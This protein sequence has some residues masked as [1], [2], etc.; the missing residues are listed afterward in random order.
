M[1]NITLVGTH[2]GEIGKSNSD[3]LYKI[4]ESLNPDVIFEELSTDHF[5]II[6]TKPQILGEPPEVKSIK[7]YLINHN[8]RHIPVDISLNPL[9]LTNDIENIFGAFKRYEVY[10]KLEEEQIEMTVKE[11]FTFLNSKRN[12]ELSEVKKI[13]ERNLIEFMPNKNQILR[14][15]NLFYEEQD[16]RENEWLQKIY[17]YSKENYYDKAIFTVGAG[18]R[19]SIMQKIQEYEKKEEFKLYWSF[20]EG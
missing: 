1:Y 3:E 5:D 7:R 10:K 6:Y 8:I 19:K 16:K 14:L 17:N 12:L 15:W 18:H 9:L 4:I 20:Y 11:G 2:H 13:T